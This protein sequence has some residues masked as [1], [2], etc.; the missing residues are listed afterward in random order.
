MIAALIA[1]G[2]LNESARFSACQSIIGQPRWKPAT[3][4][5]SAAPASIGCALLACSSQMLTL[6]AQASAAAVACCGTCHQLSFGCAPSAGPR[7]LT[8]RHACAESRADNSGG[9]AASSLGPTFQPPAIHD[10]RRFSISVNTFQL[11][12]GGPIITQMLIEVLRPLGSSPCDIA[13][14]AC[15]YPGRP[16]LGRGDTTSKL[17]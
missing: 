17:N 16:L 4:Y 1:P 8:A 7:Y 6:R 9:R 13:L 14:T 3:S 2:R 10:S 12:I 5:E 11:K 15:P